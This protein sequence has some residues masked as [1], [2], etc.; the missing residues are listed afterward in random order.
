VWD[1]ATPVEISFNGVSMTTS[2]IEAAKALRDSAPSV[3]GAA[4]TTTSDMA[5][6]SNME[7]RNV[8]GSNAIPTPAKDIASVV[9]EAMKV[10]D[11]FYSD[12][13]KEDYQ[14]KMESF[15]KFYVL[16][17][18]GGKVFYKL[19]EAAGGKLDQAIFGEIFQKQMQEGKITD[20]SGSMAGTGLGFTEMDITRAQLEK[21]VPRAQ[22]LTKQ[23]EG[24]GYKS[25]TEDVLIATSDN[26]I[27]KQHVDMKILQYLL[28]QIL[29]TEKKQLQGVWNLPEG[30]SF[31]VP[32]QSMIG[33]GDG[34]KG[35]RGKLDPSIFAPDATATEED[36]WESESVTDKIDSIFPSPYDRYNTRRKEEFLA[37]RDATAV[38]N[39]DYYQRHPDEKPGI[40]AVASGSTDILDR[41]MAALSG[42]FTSIA[43]SQGG[44][45]GWPGVE[46]PQVRGAGAA[47]DK[48]LQFEHLMREYAGGV[49]PGG[50]M[51][52][53]GGDLPPIANKIDIN[54]SS[55][56]QLTVDGRI[57]ATVIKPYL[58]SDLTNTTQASGGFSRS[59]VI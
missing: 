42:V 15:E 34:G 38:N 27:T 18:E 46:A 32:L 6:L 16:A 9:E 30:A 11:R 29:E 14:I 33:G 49:Q 47:G 43:N 48:A 53:G 44:R 23:L 28:G 55:T 35:G 56:T 8:Y 10:Q 41:L 25:S 39:D 22:A 3:F 19:V 21:Y 45:A 59:Y 54:F 12:L 7:T 2:D 13:S 24:K 36:N 4:I 58:A 17:E 52:G 20:T 51:R 31:W 57:L 26:Q 40:S 1:S 50:S 5:R 37:N